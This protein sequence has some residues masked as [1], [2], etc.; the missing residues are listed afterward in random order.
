MNKGQAILDAIVLM[1]Q[2]GMQVPTHVAQAEDG[3]LIVEWRADRS[4]AIATFDG[5][6][7]F[8][9]A[10]VDDDTVTAATHDGRVED[11]VPVE[12]TQFLV[13]MEPE[14]HRHRS[15]LIVEKEAP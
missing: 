7:R 15:W 9:V 1:K 12:L 5:T 2:V 11:F 8:G 6:G 4:K 13:N 10:I 14:L 3:E